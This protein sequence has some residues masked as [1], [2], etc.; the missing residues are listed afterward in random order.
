MA[1]T[2]LLDTNILSEP[3]RKVPNAHVME[4]LQSGAGKIAMAATTWHE[5]LFGLLRMPA[6][7]KRTV[8]EH[9]F[10][11]TLQKEIPILSY[12]ADAAAW[13]AAERARLTKIGRPPSY[14]DGQI[15]AIAATN[16]L[17]LVTRNM[18]DFDHFADL[19]IE[20]WFEMS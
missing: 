3:M 15:A 14:P 20:N 17:T 8:I 1:I 18:P 19:H 10:F 16:N 12:D 5:L 4:Q 6:S 7:Y 11:N 13:F 9:Y 2:Y